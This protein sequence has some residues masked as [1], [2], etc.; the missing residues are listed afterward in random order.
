[1]PGNIV[2]INEHHEYYVGDSKMSE[3]MG[4]LGDIGHPFPFP[5]KVTCNMCKHK[6]ETRAKNH[7]RVQCPECK[8]RG[9]KFVED[10]SDVGEE[11]N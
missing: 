6:W 2:T 9:L 4:L 8:S 5:A 11:I 10:Y 1:M 7:R 3:L